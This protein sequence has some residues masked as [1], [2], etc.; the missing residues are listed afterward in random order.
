MLAGSKGAQPDADAHVVHFVPFDPVH[1][2]SEAT[3]RDA[4][5]EFKVTKGAPQVIMALC[6]DLGSARPQVDAA[7]DTFAARGYRSLGVARS[8]DGEAWQMLGVLS[9]YDP[10][11]SRTRRRPSKPREQWASRSR[12]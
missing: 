6:G 1:K 12:W 7:I 9:L 5:G 11:R 2:R 4:R 10:P 8:R 3:V